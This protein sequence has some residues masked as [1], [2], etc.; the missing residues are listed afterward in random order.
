M[1]MQWT[2]CTGRYPFFPQHFI[3]FTF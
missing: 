3:A 1:L 2:C